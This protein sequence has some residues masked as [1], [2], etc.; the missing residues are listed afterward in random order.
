MCQVA[1]HVSASK[2]APGSMCMP[3]KTAVVHAGETHTRGPA[4]W[5]APVDM[6]WGRYL[7]DVG[8]VALGVKQGRHVVRVAHLDLDQPSLAVGIFVHE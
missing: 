7:A 2:S 6:N 5:G 8:L 1:H 3:T 4:L